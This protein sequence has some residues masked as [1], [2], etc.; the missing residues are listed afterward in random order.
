MAEMN[1][2]HNQAGRLDS[3][4]SIAAFF[5]RDE[6]TVK[7]WER[8]R[9]LPVHR[10]PGRRGGVYAY[11]AEITEWMQSP[12]SSVSGSVSLPPTSYSS[13]IPEASPANSESIE[14]ASSGG[15]GPPAGTMGFFLPKI[16]WITVA[17]L[18]AVVGSSLWTLVA[19]RGISAPHRNS[20]AA[21]PEVVDLYLKGRYHWE[22]RTPEDL[23]KAVQYFN[24][25]IAKDGAY[26][27]AY[28]GLADTYNLLRE[29]TSMPDSEAYPLALAAARKA[30]ELDPNSAQAHTA[31]AFGTFY[32][33]WDAESAEREFRRALEL[34]P[35]SAVAHHWYATFLFTD[36]RPQ[37]ALKEIEQA[38][39]LDPAS[40]AIVA[41]KALI[42]DSTG[43]SEGAI[44][45]LK[46]VKETEPNAIS[47]YRYLAGI[48]WERQDYPAYF[49]EVRKWASLAHDNERLSLVN[50]AEAGYA[51]GGKNGMLNSLLTLEEQFYR[52][53]RFSPYELAGTLAQLGRKQDALAYLETAF[54]VHDTKL[55]ELRGD[56]HLNTLRDEPEFR[57]LL[58][59]FGSSPVA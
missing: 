4:K 56:C 24:Q 22:K 37:E 19:K 47:S 27:P 7:R 21:S 45:L 28:V 5:G 44:A 43:D 41:D 46:Q 58:H 13:E 20:T 16:A 32:W 25:A 33:D 40:T 15:L 34:D 52:E 11:A 50:A 55:L 31:L 42:L 35:K 14:S 17:V 30:V 29:Y 1:A 59:R 57:A 38:R 2:S 26:A 9:G 48:Y 8:E 6:R 51:A 36:G 12:D 3:W 10:L 23:Q 39:Q 54:R 18:V 49:T 53:G